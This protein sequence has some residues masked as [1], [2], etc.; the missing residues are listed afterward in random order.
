VNGGRPLACLLVGLGM[1]WCVGPV[2][3]AT[4]P[5]PSVVEGDEV[6]ALRLLESAV[7]VSRSRTWSATQHVTTYV[8]GVPA[9]STAYL[10]HVPGQGTA[11]RVVPSTDVP[12]AADVFD[13][14]LLSL[15]DTNFDLEVMRVEPCR[16]RPAHLIQVSRPG[17]RGSA[18]VA[19]R[20]WVD[21]ATGLVLRRD[22]LDGD[23]RVLRS[24][25]LLDLAF[26]RPAASLALGR[27]LVPSGRHL[28]AVGLAELVQQGWQAPQWLPG[29]LTLYDARVMERSGGPVVQLA[30]SDGLSTLSVFQQRGVVR[31]TSGGLVRKVGRGTVW[32]SFDTPLRMVW[33]TRGRTWTVVSDAPPQVVDEAVRALP[34]EALGS[35]QDGVGPRVWRGMSRV[36][37]WLNPFS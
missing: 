34:H 33:S 25:E 19:A 10:E 24:N 6:G 11:V 21:T 9:L 1:A 22:V 5:E 18:A 13:A 30:Y 36:G 26:P 12:V 28:D 4:A 2:R 8:D 16:G 7:E 35:T 29:G 20:F 27:Q 14:D 17:Q 15:L 31:T 3:A 23:G 32:Q 37:A